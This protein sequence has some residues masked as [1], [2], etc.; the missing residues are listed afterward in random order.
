[1]QWYHRTI[2]TIREDEPNG[3]NQN[4]TGS[5]A[6]APRPTCHNPGRRSGRAIWG[7]VTTLQRRQTFQYP[8][9]RKLRNRPVLQREGGQLRVM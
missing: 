2:E 3:D 9:G 7:V 5:V 1:M 6:L 4:G 8:G